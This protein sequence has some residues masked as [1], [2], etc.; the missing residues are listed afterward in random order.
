VRRALLLVVLLA[1][2]S[3]SIATAGTATL[4]TE[5]TLTLA[6]TAAPGERNAI[7]VRV[8]AVI[9]QWPR[10]HS[11]RDARPAH[12]RLRTI[13]FSDTHAGIRP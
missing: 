6:Y 8:D 2:A 5:P 13:D 3:P 7:A 11:R 10:P 1:L 9:W 12:L 4:L